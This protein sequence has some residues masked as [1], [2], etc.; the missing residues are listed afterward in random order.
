MR[1]RSESEVVYQAEYLMH[2]R[3][4]DVTSPREENRL[5]LADVQKKVRAPAFLS[6]SNHAS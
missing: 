4:L 6:F 1:R 3:E 2:T 5:S